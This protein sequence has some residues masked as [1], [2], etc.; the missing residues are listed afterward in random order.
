MKNRQG[1]E[2]NSSVIM[3]LNPNLYGSLQL[4]LLSSIGVESLFCRPVLL[5]AS[6]HQLNQV[7][8]VSRSIQP[9]NQASFL[10]FL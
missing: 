5:D 8:E 1:Q 10:L 9:V 2:A 3:E 7:L 6:S 4:F